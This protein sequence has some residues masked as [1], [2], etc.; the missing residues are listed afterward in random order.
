M[1]APGRD[2]LSSK[3]S[4]LSKCSI[5]RCGVCSTI[6]LGKQ[7]ELVELCAADTEACSANYQNLVDDYDLF[8]QPL[9][10][11]GGRGFPSQVGLDAGPLLGQYMEAEAI[12]SQ[13]GFAQFLQEEH[14]LDLDQVS[15]LSAMAA[16]V[17]PLGNKRLQLNQHKNPAYQPVRNAPTNIAGREYSGHALDRMQDRGIM[18]SVIEDTI[19]NGQS[20][21][22]RGGTTLFHSAE[23]NISVVVNGQGSVVTT[24]YGR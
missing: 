23:N 3:V 14:G 17:L 21:P 22:S 12:V 20:S 19:R 8:R 10:R 1:E 7:D 6:H 18:P 4:K 16:G 11:L 2:E 5:S 13:E 15:V 9:D 24:R